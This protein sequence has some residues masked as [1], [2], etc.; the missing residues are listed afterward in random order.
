MKDTNPA[1][2]PLGKE[3][4]TASCLS[5]E[6]GGQG[7]RALHAW[8]ASSHYLYLQWNWHLPLFEGTFKLN[9]NSDAEINA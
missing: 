7:R 9:S 5:S 1:L 2:R 6:A 4:E 3:L 8:V